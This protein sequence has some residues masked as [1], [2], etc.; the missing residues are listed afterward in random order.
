[1]Y[2]EAMD[3]VNKEIKATVSEIGT[4]IKHELRKAMGREILNFISPERR[5]IAEAAKSGQ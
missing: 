5:A 3:G 1:M 4:V 2:E